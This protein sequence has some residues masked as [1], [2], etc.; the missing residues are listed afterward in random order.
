MRFLS[1]IWSRICDR[2]LE[3]IRS[4]HICV[5]N[6]HVYCICLKIFPF[7]GIKR[8]CVANNLC[9][10]LYFFRLKHEENLMT[11]IISIFRKHETISSIELNG[12]IFDRFIYKIGCCIIDLQCK[13]FAARFHISIIEGD[14]KFIEAFMRKYN[15]VELNSI[16]VNLGKEWNH[17][18]CNIGH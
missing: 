10:F 3:G 1:K 11:L 2:K 12:D 17:W 18:Q 15:R 8:Q 6:D 16:R 4:A 7:I 9:E 13:V 14:L 5:T